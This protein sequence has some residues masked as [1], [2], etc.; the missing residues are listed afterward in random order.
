MNMPL[1]PTRTIMPPLSSG[2]YPKMP[3][4]SG[5][6]RRISSYSRAMVECYR[7]FLLCAER[8]C[9]GLTDLT[10][11]CEP[12]PRASGRAARRLQAARG[13]SRTG[14]AAAAPLSMSAGV[15]PAHISFERGASAPGQYTAARQVQREVSRPNYSFGS[16]TSRTE[17]SPPIQQGLRL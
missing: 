16:A 3:N 13:D 7:M 11:T 2:M 4:A 12:P 9:D 10:L 5:V 17:M 6:A 14:A 8:Y 15:T 1:P